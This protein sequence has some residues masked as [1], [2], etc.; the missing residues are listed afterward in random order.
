MAN[1]EIATTIELDLSDREKVRK[2]KQKQAEY[3]RRIRGD[4]F[5]TYGKKDARNKSAVIALL[6]KNGRVTLE[7]VL[8]VRRADGDF[9]TTN[10]DVPDLIEDFRVIVC[11][12]YHGGVHK[13]GGTG[14]GGNR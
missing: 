9:G 14:F 5:D 3:E 7:E 11:Y 10:W 2:L 13:R 12:V 1:C 6:T 8:E 4:Q